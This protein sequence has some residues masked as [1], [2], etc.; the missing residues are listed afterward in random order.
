MF[1]TLKEQPADK[2]LMLMQAYREDPREQ[3]IDLGVGV[4]RDEQ[5]HTPIMRA[6]KR[7]AERGVDHVLSCAQLCCECG[8][9][10]TIVGAPDV[11]A[12]ED[13][14]VTARFAERVLLDADVGL[15]GS[16]PP[17]GMYT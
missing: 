12:L 3:K 10:G 17:L 9:D 16:A 2:I 14:E 4:Y 1:E 5:G 6:V 11:E 8:G 7:E 13:Q 15:R